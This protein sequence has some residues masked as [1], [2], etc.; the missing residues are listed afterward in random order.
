MEKQI[1]NEK[2]SLNADLKELELEIQIQEKTIRNLT[3]QLELADVKAGKMGVVT[4]V[5]DAI[6]ATVHPGD[7]IAR[8]A[9][10]TSF[11]VEGKISDIHASKIMVGNPVRVRIGDLNLSGSISGIQPTIQNGVITFTVGLNDKTNRE[12][13]SNLRVDVFVITS[14]RKDV[15]RIKNGPFI[16]GPG[17]QE[18]FVIDGKTAIRRKVLIGDTNFDWAEVKE[19]LAPGETVIISDMQRYIHRESLTVKE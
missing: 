13:R 15:I 19:G 5:N 18:V 6:G 7:I 11:K 8:V 4:W 16:N 12:L 10:L 3:R 17:E 1:A 14:F 9:D 2:K